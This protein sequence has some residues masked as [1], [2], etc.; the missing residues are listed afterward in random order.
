MALQL[1][2]R[3]FTVDQYHQMGEVGILKD[4]DRVELIEGEIIDMTPIGVRHAQCVA[5]LTRALVLQL[6]R[7][8]LVWAQN[9]VRLSNKTEVQP[10]I[11]LLRNRDYSV[12]ES[13]P[14]PEH[15]LLVV[16]VSDSTLAYD[17]REKLLLYA[18]A[19]IP[20]YWLVNLKENVIEVYSDPAGDEYQ[21]VEQARPGDALAVPG[22][23]GVT[24]SVLDIL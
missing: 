19:G 8:A 22:F 10:D 6:E 23:S 17:E 1:T 11:A 20:E 16:E 15:I 14:G 21:T 7:S 9:P 2:R 24:V 13:A 5:K 18:R 12:D 3:R 4:D